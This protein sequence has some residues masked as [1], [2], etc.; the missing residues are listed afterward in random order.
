MYESESPAVLVSPFHIFIVCARL[1]GS[2][3]LGGR[4]SWANQFGHAGRRFG[5]VED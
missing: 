5:A 2:S 3:G 4:G 1:G